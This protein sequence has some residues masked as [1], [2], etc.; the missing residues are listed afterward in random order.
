MH[1]FC[2]L[3]VLGCC[4]AITLAQVEYVASCQAC[5]NGTNKDYCPFITIP[6]QNFISSSEA[7]TSFFTIADTLG[8]CDCYAYESN[9]IQCDANPICNWCENAN[10]C[11][12]QTSGC[13]Q[14]TLPPTTAPTTV[15]SATAAPT[16]ASSSNTVLIGGIVLTVVVVRIHLSFRGLYEFSKC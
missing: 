1:T 2:L 16:A 7:G 11:G 3:I 8:E 4:I 12:T 6:C 9:R 10:Y 5:L 13:S 14:P 15:A